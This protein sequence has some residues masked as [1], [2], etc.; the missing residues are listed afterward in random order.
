MLIL[1]KD[2]RYSDIDGALEIAWNGEWLTPSQIAYSEDTPNS[3]MTLVNRFHQ[4]IVTKDSKYKGLTVED[5]VMRPADGKKAITG[6]IDQCPKVLAV[7]I[8]WVC[9]AG[10]ETPTKLWLHTT[11]DAVCDEE[12][13]A[14]GR[15]RNCWTK[16][17]ESRRNTNGARL[18]AQ[19]DE[20]K[21]K[22]KK[23]EESPQR[24]RNK[25]LFRDGTG[26]WL[27]KNEGS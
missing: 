20:A 21:A 27:L 3:S 14:N 12:F 6:R 1:G 17:S 9:G 24:T 19:T 15:C 16:T 10:V 26:L 8:V 11:T 7:D 22:A 18:A 25:I 2:Y 13:Y 23:R 4:A 5:L